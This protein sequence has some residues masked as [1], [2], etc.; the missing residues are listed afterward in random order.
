MAG[1][2]PAW[3]Q[4]IWSGPRVRV[5]ENSHLIDD[6]AIGVSDDEM[7]ALREE[8]FRQFAEAQELEAL[9]QLESDK[10]KEAERSERLSQLEELDIS[11]EE[12]EPDVALPNTISER[13]PSASSRIS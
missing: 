6:I 11:T 10:R 3:Y 8:A 9:K 12:E 7:Q 13:T 5:L 4:S 1:K 2:P